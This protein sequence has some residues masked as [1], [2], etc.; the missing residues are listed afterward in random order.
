MA[1]PF[2]GKCF[3]TAA[4]FLDYLDDIKFGAWRPRF[5]TV[6]HTGAPNLKT[7]QGWQTRSKD[8]P[9]TVAQIKEHNAVGKKI[10]GWGARAK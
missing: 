9:K 3:P 4:Q 7:W 10:C 6:H 1:I 8:T 5:V 2:V